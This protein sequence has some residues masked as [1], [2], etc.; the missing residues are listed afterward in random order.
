MKTAQADTLQILEK[1]I[2][3]KKSMLFSAMRTAELR[4]IA[5][6]A[7]EL[8]FSDNDA[9]VRENDIGDSMYLIRT[10]EVAIVKGSGGEERVELARLSAGDCFGE[11]AVF[12]TEYR[13]AGAF[14]QGICTILR[15]SSDD[16][17]DVIHEQPNVALGLLRIFVRRLK[18]ADEVIHKLT[19]DGRRRVG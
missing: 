17:V 7:E 1:V 19:V 12:D 6:V 5:A 2:F 11:M 8:S 18:K 14:A 16:L 3:L 10:G 4:A 15:I 13:S 9:I